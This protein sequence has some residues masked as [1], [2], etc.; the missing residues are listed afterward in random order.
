MHINKASGR[1]TEILSHSFN[2]PSTGDFETALLKVLIP[3][4]RKLR[5]GN[6]FTPVCQSFCSGAQICI[7]ETPLGPRPPDRDPRGQRP[8]LD[9][10]PLDRDLT[11]RDPLDRDPPAQRPADRDP[12]HRDPLPVTVT[13][14]RYASY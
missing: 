7:R 2:N 10:D 11:D 4:A 12:L 1:E 3:P 8:H 6:V 14:G 5:Q 13:G 9:R